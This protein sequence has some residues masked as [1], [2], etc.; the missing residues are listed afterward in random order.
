MKLCK[1]CAYLLP[2]SA[3]GN[4]H[5]PQNWEQVPDFVNGGDKRSHI[6]THFFRAQACR[7]SERACGKDAQWFVS[8]EAE[9]AFSAYATARAK[10]PA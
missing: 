5:A 2:N 4:C 10:M 3:G 6:P 9:E 7:E 1:N 8:K